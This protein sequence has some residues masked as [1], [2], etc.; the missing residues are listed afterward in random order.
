MKPSSEAL[1]VE[2]RSQQIQASNFEQGFR[3]GMWWARFV[4]IHWDQD[5]SFKAGMAFVQCMR[6]TKG[7]ASHADFITRLHELDGLLGKPPT[8]EDFKKGEANDT[9]N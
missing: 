1:E 7:Y 2:M 5:L 9:D 6:A 4:T 8:Q 3:V